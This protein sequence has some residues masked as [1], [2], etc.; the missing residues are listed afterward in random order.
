MVA[1]KLNTPEDTEAMIDQGVDFV[2]LG[3]AGILNH[4][5]PNRYL[6]DPTF[7]ATQLP[8]NVQ[9]LEHEGVS[10]AFIKYLSA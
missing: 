4:D 7:T 1:G 2:M 6:S 3:R 8:V 9:H 5:F 10:P